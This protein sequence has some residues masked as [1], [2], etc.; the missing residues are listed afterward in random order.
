MHPR[1]HRV[2]RPLSLIFHGDSLG[3]PQQQRN[4]L[5]SLMSGFGGPSPLGRGNRAP[6][7]GPRAQERA[8]T[9][10]AKAAMITAT[11]T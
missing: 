8:A 1:L 9:S 10:R 4:R 7:A 2:D 11:R 6:R 3:A 5:H